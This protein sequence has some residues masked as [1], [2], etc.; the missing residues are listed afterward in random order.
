MTEPSDRANRL[1]AT[2]RG[3]GSCVVAYSGGVDS[4]VVAQAAVLALG[5]HAVA[6]T[7]SSDSLPAGELDA[8]TQLAAQI[9]IRHR[10]VTTREFERPDYVRNAPDRCYHCK[11]ELYGLLERVRAELNLAVVV[12][13]TNA[14]DP[15][16]FRPGLTAAAEHH[17]RA[18]L[19]ECGLT[20][21]DV[22]ELAQFWNLPIWDKPATPCLSSRV[23]YGLEVTPERLSKVDAAERALR[24]R[25]F[26]TCRVRVHPGELARIEV[27][28]TDLPR[29][30]EPETRA[31]IVATMSR[32]GFNYVTLDLA[33]F[34]SGSFAPLI[35]LASLAATGTP[36]NVG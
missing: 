29:L 33:G 27:D 36:A 16:D 18:P 26:R 25:G 1:I 2:I 19:L 32:I 8:A 6:V 13:G 28:L 34:R 9:G 15:S 3:Y 17:V 21:R 4:A 11:T 10:I 12:A 35:S 5:E 14:D 24:E 30:A 22:R 7:G 23:A 20:K 31:E